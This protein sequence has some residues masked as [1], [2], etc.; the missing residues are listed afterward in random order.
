MSKVSMHFDLPEERE[1]F[2]SAL[3]GADY[4]I[5]LWDIAQEIFRPARKHGYS[6]ANINDAL[7]ICNGHGEK[8]IG[9][10]E[11]KFYEI[12]EQRGIKL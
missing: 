2:E 8:L 1:D 9:A 6:E 12:L 5:A 4:K 7:S 10:L 3:Y 11:K